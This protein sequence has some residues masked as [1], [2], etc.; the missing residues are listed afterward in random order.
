MSEGDDDLTSLA[1]RVAEAARPVPSAVAPGTDLAAAFPADAAAGSDLPL[2]A[3]GIAGADQL[4]RRWKRQLSGPLPRR[5]EGRAPGAR[6]SSAP[7]SKREKTAYCRELKALINI[8]RTHIYYVCQLHGHISTRF[9]GD[10]MGVDRQPEWERHVTFAIVHVCLDLGR[11]ILLARAQS[12]P[13]CEPA[14]GEGHSHQELV[15][16]ID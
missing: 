2:V 5:Q 15:A 14:G 4:R 6:A 9:F 3:A 7:R 16:V 12:P 8:M 11:Q 1:L 10:L 13:S